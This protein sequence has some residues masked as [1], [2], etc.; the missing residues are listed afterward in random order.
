MKVNRFFSLSPPEEPKRVKLF[1]ELESVKGG[2]I[3]GYVVNGAW[4]FTLS[5]GILQIEGKSEDHRFPVI[6]SW[7]GDLPGGLGDYNNVMEYIERRINHWRIT[8]WM[9]DKRLAFLRELARC[10]RAIGAAKRA[11]LKVYEANSKFVE[12]EEDTIPF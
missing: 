5:E 6:M 2:V 11:Y 3:K 12:D 8:N 10:N 4:S 7:T 9:I 1:C